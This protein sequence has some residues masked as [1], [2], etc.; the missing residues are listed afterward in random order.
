VSA[1]I[2]LVHD[3]PAFSNDLAA[4]L[5]VKGHEVA[6][7]ND[8]T[9]P[10]PAPHASNAFEI[11]VVRPAEIK[12]G[13]RIKVIGIPAGK[14]YDGPMLKYMVEPISVAD[15]TAALNAFLAPPARPVVERRAAPR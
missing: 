7:S 3:D 12:S 1:R 4:S 13:L 9:M 11:A 6:V 8:L 14:P 5:R 2:V 10:V 15:V